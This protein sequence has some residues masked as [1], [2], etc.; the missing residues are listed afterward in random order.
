M[1]KARLGAVML[2]EVGQKGDRLVMDLV[3]DL[4]DPLDV[5]LAALAYRLRGAGRDD[6]ELLLGL[7]GECLDFELD[8][9]IIFR[10]PDRRHLRPAV[11]REHGEAP[12]PCASVS[13]PESS[14]SI[15]AISPSS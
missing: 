10:L 1:H 3:L 14:T 8:A 15:F 2:G 7:A 6:S 9:E 11:A 5:E 13:A 12:P 4:P